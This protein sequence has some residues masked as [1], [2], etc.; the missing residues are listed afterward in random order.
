MSG[1]GATR[2]QPAYVSD[3]GEAIAR[4][5]D[6]QGKPGADYE[7]GGPEIKT[8]RELMAFICATLGRKRLLLPVPSAAA[9]YPAM[10]TEIVNSVLL[11][12][13]PSALLL[14]RDQLKLLE[15]D[16]VVSE[17]ATT[18]RQTFDGLGIEPQALEAIVPTYLYRFR[19]TGQFERNQEAL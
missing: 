19:K 12:A 15:Q 1:G 8:F 17:G 9:Y 6:G 16:N 11:G 7:F 4:L 14:S 3:V 2:F 5:V 18:A 10:A 13:L